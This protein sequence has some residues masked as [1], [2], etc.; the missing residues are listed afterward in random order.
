ME[1][2]I[3]AWAF[4]H[5]NYSLVMS[6]VTFQDMCPVPDRLKNQQPRKLFVKQSSE[7]TNGMTN[8]TIESK[9]LR[10]SDVTVHCTGA[11]ASFSCPE[12]LDGTKYM[13]GRMGFKEKHSDTRDIGPQ[14][15]PME[16]RLIL[17]LFN[18]NSSHVS[19]QS[20]HNGL[21]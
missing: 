19:Q 18:Q 20:P 8:F 12:A 3:E 21:Y 9:P 14:G 13:T 4:Q 5:K 15:N 1:A 17:S 6:E 2:A 11:M 16:H 10:D 7:E